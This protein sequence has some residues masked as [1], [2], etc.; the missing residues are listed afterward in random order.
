[1]FGKLLPG[2]KNRKVETSL[3]EEFKY[4]K[5]GP[6]QLWDVTASEVEKRGGKVLRNHRVVGVVKDANNHLT[7]VKVEVQS[8]L[9]QYLSVKDLA[10]V[11]VVTDRPPESPW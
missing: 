8:L 6:G 10:P 3:I 9:S 2:K 11:P 1:M 7:A 4:P 5:L